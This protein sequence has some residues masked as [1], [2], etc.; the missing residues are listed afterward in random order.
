MCCNLEWKE[1]KTEVPTTPTL[2]L[3]IEI[4]ELEDDTTQLQIDAGQVKEEPH[5]LTN[6]LHRLSI[7]VDIKIPWVKA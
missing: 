5:E 4:K 2:M 3:K 7:E 1:K 6:Q